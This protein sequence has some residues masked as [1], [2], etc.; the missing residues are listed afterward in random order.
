M[1]QVAAMRETIKVAEQRLGDSTLNLSK[2]MNLDETLQ[3]DHLKGMLS[4]MEANYNPQK[5]GEGF[6]EAKLGRW[7]GW[8]QAACVAMGVVTLDDMKKINRLNG[9]SNDWSG[10]KYDASN[11]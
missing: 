1:N 4:M 8:A 9:G 11:A 6:S 3:L 7:L 5:P 10:S 2:I